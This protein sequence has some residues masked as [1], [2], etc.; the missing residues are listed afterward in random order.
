[1]GQPLVILS[2]AHLSRAYGQ[3]SGEKLAAVV[4]EHRDCELI[5]A[6][7]IFDLSLEGANVGIESGLDAALAPHQNL[8]SNLSK[9]VQRGNKITFIPGNHDAT[10][11]EDGGDSLRRHLKPLSDDC[12]E[13]SPWF[14]RRG[15]VHIEHGHL[16]D[17]DC[18]NNHPLAKPNPR[19]EGLGTALMRRFISPNDALAFAHANQTTPAEGLYR[20]FLEW[21]PRAPLVITNYFRT[22][23]TLCLEAGLHKER[24]RRELLQG[25][26]RIVAHAKKNRLDPAVLQALLVFAPE[27]T[28][29]SFRAT[30][31]R[32]YFD[33]I[34]AGMSLSLGVGMLASAG[35]GGHLSASSLITSSGALTLPGALLAA[36]GGGYLLTNIRKKKNRYGNAVINQLGEAARGVAALTKSRLVVFGHTHVEVNEPGYVN[37]GSF[38]YGRPERPY[39]LVDSRGGHERRCISALQSS[40][41]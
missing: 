33:R 22:A 35:M 34:S 12:V 30:F 29:Q 40:I 13:V 15:D 28:H 31:Q 37:L 5:L 32:L 9:H 4:A 39:L 3:H 25:E 41:L 24:V 19:S 20:A 23:V 27:P 16:Y 18:A 8:L 26:S 7:D 10:M 17:P 2:D 11:A 36:I 14:V 21:G 6:G 38:G 1:M